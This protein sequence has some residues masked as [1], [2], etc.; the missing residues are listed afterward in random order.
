MKKILVLLLAMLLLAGVACAEEAAM[1]E[2]FRAQLDVVLNCMENTEELA[3]EKM[4]ETDKDGNVLNG[5]TSCWRASMADG[6]ACYAYFDKN[7]RVHGLQLELSNAPKAEE[8]EEAAL[9]NLFTGD[10]EAAWK[11]LFDAYGYTEADVFYW[12]EPR[13]LIQDGAYTNDDWVS[14][15]G[16]RG[17]GSRPFDNTVVELR[18]DPQYARIYSIGIFYMN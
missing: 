18:W 15:Y 4:I 3:F 13:K 11:N 16:F 2:A 12:G 1:P 10:T 17:D 9:Y 5:L 14:F 8:T 6:A 7:E